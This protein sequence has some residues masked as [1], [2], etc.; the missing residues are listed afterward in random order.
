[1]KKETTSL[2]GNFFGAKKRSPAAVEQARP[3]IITSLSQSHVLQ[4]KM[5]EERLTHGETVTANLSPVR[6]ESHLGKMILYFCPMENI[7]VLQTI[8]EGDG[9][10]IPQQAIVEDLTIPSNLKAGYYI[11]KNVTLTSNG[12]MQVKATDETV[13]ENAT[14]YYSKMF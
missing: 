9:G 4:Q 13:W 7:Q 3:V 12:T 6:L 8:T 14:P 10:S 2:F 11:L 1:M 5:Q